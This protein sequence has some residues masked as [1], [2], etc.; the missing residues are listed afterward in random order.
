MPD[1]FASFSDQL[2]LHVRNYFI[3]EHSISLQ[4]IRI[5][6]FSILFF[7]FFLTANAQDRSPSDSAP[8]IGLALSG[9]GAK[10]FAHIGV[11][12]VL[13]EA[14]LQIDVLSG[15]SMGSIVGG[16]YAI[17]YTPAQLEELAINHRWKKILNGRPLRQHHSIFNKPYAS[18]TLLRTP[19]KN[20]GIGL[21]RGVVKG[22]EISMLLNNLTQPYHHISDFSRLPIPFAAVAT[23]L[24]TGKP[25]HL[26]SGYLPLVMQAS[27]TLP[28]LLQPVTIDSATYIDA[29]A[30]RNI[31]VTDARRL[32]AD[33]IITSDVG[34]PV[35]P[36]DSLSAFTDVVS[37]AIRFNHVASNEKQR[38][39]SD[40]IIKP[41]ITGFS[42]SDFSKAAQLIQNGERAA[43]KILP[44]LKALA[45]SIQ[46]KPDTESPNVNSS[47]PLLIEE[48]AIQG[49][50]ASQ[51]RWLK[52]ALHFRPPAR[53]TIAEI[54]TI[55]DRM[56]YADLFSDISYRLPK[57]Q[58]SDGHTLVVDIKANDP[59][60]LGL[61]A[62]Y[63]SEYKTSLLLSGTFKRLMNP[64]DALTAHLRLGQQLQLGGMYQL[65]FSLYPE[66]G[67]TIEGRADRSLIDLYNGSEQRSTVKVE[68]LYFSAGA[69]F[70]ILSDLWVGAGVK[71]EVY[72]LNEPLANI[73]TF[74]DMRG[75]LLGKLSISS[76]TLNRSRFASRGHKLMLKSYF[77]NT[78]WGSAETFSQYLADGQLQTPLNASISLISRITLG[79]TYGGDGSI[80]L[81]YRYYSGGSVPPPAFKDRQFLLL[82]YDRQQLSARN[83]RMLTLGGQL[84][85]PQDFI[86]QLLWN[87]ASLTD[88]WTYEIDRSDF[89]S[90]IG[91]R[92]GKRTIAGPAELILATQEFDGPYS[93]RISVGY[94]F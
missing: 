70:A 80:P 66:A 8:K 60:M 71:S 65:P 91:L 14:G 54:E 81:H 73:F 61:G 62:R 75:L 76:N 18:Q 68:Q 21:P 1:L 89:N 25:V 45:D 3:I 48:V 22:H 23:D 58:G 16:L 2:Q 41:D 33:F 5:V 29:T 93:L 32:G 27:S 82:G 78:A 4:C 79:H 38:R 26:N 49:G 34:S 42:S 94:S 74:R 12:K 46:Q 11:L 37:Q 72:N 9:G 28:G 31:P 88:E 85:L 57:K 19:F 30:S 13:E 20:G 69:N 77:S 36:A 59:Q 87:S 40:I 55:I 53:M 56:Y 83:L 63:D 64:R 6:L 84:N 47:D 67:L 86:V 43:R 35:K 52:K 92:L 50:N 51:R 15:A 17:G 10:G 7:G 39:L 90:G 44:R 24:S